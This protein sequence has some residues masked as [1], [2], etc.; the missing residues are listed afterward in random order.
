MYRLSTPLSA[1]K[2]IGPVIATALRARDFEY[3]KDL[4]LFLPLRYED[5]S[6]RKKIAELEVGELVTIEA[7]VRSSSNY[8][9]GRKSIQSASVKDETGKLKLMW[10]N[11]P[12]IVSRLKTGERFLIS[13]KL[14]DRGAMTQPTVEGVSDDSIH[15]GRLVPIYPVIPGVAPTTLRKLLKLILDNLEAVPD[16][17]GQTPDLA[18]ALQQ[19]HFP[20]I[21]DAVVTARERFALEE[22]LLLIQH[23]H[24]LKVEWK[25]GDPAIAIR[26]VVKTSAQHLPFALTPAQERCVEEIVHDLQSVIPMNRLLVGDVGSGK[27][28][29]AGIAC[30]NMLACDHN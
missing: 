30:V 19:I 29:V 9:K 26:D 18:T 12:Y 8:Y 20:D 27:T 22:L 1:V 5:R 21:E 10:F 3:V 11:N 25:K 15:T 7:E 17:L 2:G 28:A 6:L 16:S 23:A 24:D 14:N 13:G 4:L